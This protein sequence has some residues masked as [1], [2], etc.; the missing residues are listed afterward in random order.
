MTADLV[1]DWITALPG[2]LLV[3]VLALPALYFPRWNLVYRLALA[4]VSVLLFS[5]LLGLMTH[6]FHFTR[7]ED[8]LIEGVGIGLSGSISELARFA[9][10]RIRGR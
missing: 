5:L 2:I 1:Q 8:L 3:A 6:E 7:P 9:I 4:C 10:S